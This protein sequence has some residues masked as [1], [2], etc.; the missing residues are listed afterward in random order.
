MQV[1]QIDSATVRHLR[2]KL[3]ASA[4][5]RGQRRDGQRN[6][7]D[8]TSPEVRALVARVS[9]ICEVLYLVMVADGESDSDE[10]RSIRG[11]I[12]T[13]TA[14]G[15]SDPAVE[16]MLQR[17]EQSVAEQGQQ[18]RLMRLAAELSAD[19]EDAEAA[20]V[21]A[22]AIAVADDSI[23]GAEESVL[24]ELSELLGISSQRAAV[25]LDTSR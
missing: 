8:E 18:E 9:S 5:L 6:R 14:G 23:A 22:A 21:L 25:I 13:L 16:S 7:L 17:Y 4:G 15:L 12:A 20:L 10:L 1:M 3:L 19:R 24:I 11:A 2:D